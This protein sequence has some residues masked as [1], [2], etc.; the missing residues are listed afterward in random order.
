MKND[1]FLILKGKYFEEIRS[2]IKT[3][4][5]RLCT[6]FWRKRLMSK[7]WRTVTFQLGYN[8][9]APR[10]RKRIVDISE[11]TVKYEFFGPD[12]VRVFEIRLA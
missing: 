5:Y 4:E 9:N 10:I 12:P 2:G 6:D 8:R 7:P 3:S 11:T 1:L